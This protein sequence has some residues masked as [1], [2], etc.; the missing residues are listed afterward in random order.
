MIH[1]SSFSLH[2]SF[3]N[4]LMKEAGFVRGTYT[5]NHENDN[6]LD[7]NEIITRNLI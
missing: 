4:E 5:L 7:V 3:Q 1:F 6:N 2:F